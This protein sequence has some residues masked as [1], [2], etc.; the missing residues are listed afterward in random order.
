[1]RFPRLA[2]FAFAGTCVLGL[3]ALSYW[4]G[5]AGSE[6][7]CNKSAIWNSR[8]VDSLIASTV[9]H[10]ENH[11]CDAVLAQFRALDNSLNSASPYWYERGDIIYDSIDTPQ[12]SLPSAN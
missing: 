2:W 3:C 6:I 9:E 1:M 7:R 4:V 8:A 10:L 12:G 5:F 11:E